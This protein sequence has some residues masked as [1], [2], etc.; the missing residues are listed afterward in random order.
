MGTAILFGLWLAL[1]AGRLIH[2][3]DNG[4]IRFSLGLLFSLVILFRRKPATASFALP[5]N[6]AVV[7]GVAGTLVAIIGIVSG[8]HQFEWIG[9]VMLLFGCLAWALPPA[10]HRDVALA[11][12]LFYWIH[13]LPSQVFAELQFAMQRMSVSGAE[14][15]LQMINERVWADGFVLRTGLATYDVPEWCSGMRT[16]TTV[17]LLAL[18]LGVA[19]RLRAWEV[20]L[21]VLAGLAQALVLNVVRLATMVLFAPRS[22]EIC[23]TE[24]LHDTVGLIVILAVLLVYLEILAWDRHRRHR[25]ADEDAMLEQHRKAFSGHPPFWHGVVT[26]RWILLAAAAALVLGA[27]LA[28]KSR[29]FHRA[30][31]IKTVAELLRDRGHLEEAH[32]AANEVMQL[33]PDDLDWRFT[34]LRLLLM[35]RRF[36]EVLTALKELPPL[37][38]GLRM[39]ADILR[40]YSLMGLGRMEE[41]QTVVVTLPQSIQDTDPRVAMIM[42]ELA[43]RADDPNEVARRLI[44]ASRWTPNTPRIRALYPYLRIRRQWAA[45]SDSDTH[46][47]YVDPVQALSATEAYMNLDHVPRV[48]DL[49]LKAM[50]QWPDDPRTLEPLFFMA[51]R[52]QGSVWEDRFAAHLVRSCGTLRDPGILYGHMGKCFDLGRPDL[53][54][55]LHRRIAAVDSTHPALSMSVVRYGNA[56]F[57]FRRRYL[58]Y[59]AG[60]DA[61]QISLAPLYLL[62]R[63]LDDW[64]WMCDQ[65]PFGDELAGSDVTAVRKAHLAIAMGEFA[66]RDAR[67]DLTP[68][69]RFEYVFALEISGDMEG[70]RSQLTRI[71]E[72]VPR[73]RD[74][75]RIMLSEVC[76]RKGR[77]V[78]V[79]EILR[80]YGQAPSPD[81]T[82]LLRLCA[83][84]LELG[85]GVGALATAERIAQRFPA[86]TQGAS[87]SATALREYDSTEE[88]LRR[89]EKA[90]SRRDRDMDMM[91]AECLYETGRFTELRAFCHTARLPT[92]YL[93]FDAEPRMTLPPAEAALLWHWFAVPASAGFESIA[94]RIRRNLPIA[95]DSPFLGRMMT[96]WLECHAEG[97]R[98][99]ASAPSA[100][101]GCGRDSTERAVALHQLALLLCHHERFAEARQAAETA[102]EI[103]PSAP[104]LWR[105]LISLSGGDPA[106]I[107][108]ARTACPND[109]EIWLSDLVVRSQAGSVDERYWVQEMTR[110]GQQGTFTAVAMTR[111][112]EYLLRGGMPAAAAVIAREAVKQARGLLPA[113]VLGIRCALLAGDK[114]WA[115]ESTRK[116][117]EASTHAPASFYRKLIELKMSDKATAIDG[118]MVEALRRLRVAEP[119][120]PLWSS[121]L[122][123]ARFTR[124]GWEVMDAYQNMQHALD[125]GATNRSVYIVA[126]EASRAMGNPARAVEILR[127]G[128]ATYP[129]DLPMMNNLALTLCATPDG[130]QDAVDLV[131][132]LITAGHDDPS[133]MD[134]VALIHVRS[135]KLDE[136][137]TLAERLIGATAPG[138]PARFRANLRLAEV[139][140]ARGNR[141]RATDILREVMRNTRG[142]PDEDV[143]HATRLLSE[144]VAETPPETAP[145]PAPAA[146][147]DD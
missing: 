90:R 17:F 111:A 91:E 85:L 95:K 129:G 8:I 27:G 18:G 30:E 11:L 116:A 103:L 53:A 94:A 105:V 60:S 128:L 124:G 41:A 145:A 62:G 47:P 1:N 77:W 92:P 123:Y 117:V 31:M 35:R 140:L 44:T 134:T 56:W 65:V 57:S 71:A 110:A 84:Q 93:G 126:A 107:T 79:Y 137:E 146:P 37:P 114:D 23:G 75:A 76:E 133:I 48:A 143:I 64:Q 50:E 13:P 16:A 54:W 24:F 21:A 89:L 43:V 32:R 101:E 121:V 42:G 122:G 20:A 113:Y 112:G 29:P 97:G 115:L 10:W 58:G 138:T 12:V 86:S 40:A 15:L 142:I 6:P 144:A 135:G 83:A 59:S 69:D 119:D 19:L 87:I 81:L 45:I 68:A 73:E 125:G 49:A 98:G 46:L 100:W 34:R 26:H 141:P 36:D 120:N 38:A 74:R 61:D 9:I 96:L 127:K 70:V 88:A 5:G 136:A 3:Q 7:V 2:D 102:V 72:L 82:P 108:R 104:L 67:G 14:W 28:Y 66:R 139:L 25:V 33:V 78:E 147:K 80:G 22:E 63:R 132:H 131:P 118:E 55:F 106:V 39:E 52:R 51:I 130:L 109:S 99:K 4:L